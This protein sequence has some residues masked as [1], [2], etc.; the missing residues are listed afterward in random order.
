[1][2]S[3]VGVLPHATSMA[4]TA[5]GSHRQATCRVM[6]GD[7]AEGVLFT[8]GGRI[9]PARM[10]SMRGGRRTLIAASTSRQGERNLAKPNFGYQK[11][12]KELEKKRKK[13]EKMKKKLE[14]NAVPPVEAAA[15]PAP[16]NAEPV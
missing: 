11:R 16:E 8:N 15:A 14:K 9:L 7:I 1:M 13:E 12:Q 6:V 4:A 10:P 5:K 2:G 3:V